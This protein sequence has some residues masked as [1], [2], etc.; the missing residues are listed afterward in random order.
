MWYLTRG[1]FP[2][3]HGLAHGLANLFVTHLLPYQ[4]SS[5]RHAFEHQYGVIS[6]YHS[7]TSYAET[8]FSL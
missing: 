2:E 3:E 7:Y 5:R 1:G 4:M 6:Q 8:M